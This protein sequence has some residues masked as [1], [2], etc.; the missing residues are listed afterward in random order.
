MNHISPISRQY[1]FKK[2][3]QTIVY[4]TLSSH[5]DRQYSVRCLHRFFAVVCRLKSVLGKV[6]FLDFQYAKCMCMHY[7]AVLAVGY[8][9]SK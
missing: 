4:M 8:R 2:N 1:L 3:T 9:R 5:Q 7:S 6:E